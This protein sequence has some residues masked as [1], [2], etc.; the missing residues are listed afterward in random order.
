MLVAAC[1]D[2]GV[3]LL[4]TVF[5]SHLP[6]SFCPSGCSLR[7]SGKLGAVSTHIPILALL[8]QHVLLTTTMLGRNRPLAVTRAR[9]ALVTSL[10]LTY[11][12]LAS[13]LTTL[14]RKRWWFAHL[15]SPYKA[16]VL[17]GISTQVQEARSRVPRVQLAWKYTSGPQ[18]PYNMS[19]LALI[20]ET[21]P[22]PH[23]VPQL[24][25]MISVVPPDWRFLFIGSA[26]SILSVSRATPIQH[27]SAIGKIAFLQLP[28]PWTIRSSEDIYRLLTD[29]R[30]YDEFLPG[31]EWILKY[32][33]DSIL[34]ANSETDLNEWLDWN[35]AGSPRYIKKS[36]STG[37]AC[38]TVF[39]Q[40]RE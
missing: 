6:F 9:L 4:P 39:T 24:L 35:W 3:E 1:L 28:T 26:R 29:V 12:F 30:F 31:V 11:G 22:L 21:R 23:L 8:M 32:E 2:S 25:H 13:P 36:H 5:I 34:C 15:V 18:Q 7:N 40:H 27:K 14:T 20:I 10:A 38:L 33:Y 19:K 17:A 16:I 37:I